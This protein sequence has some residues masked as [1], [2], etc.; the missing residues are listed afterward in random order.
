[1]NKRM[2]FLRDCTGDI[3]G[4]KQGYATHKGAEAATRHPNVKRQLRDTWELYLMFNPDALTVWSIKSEV[5]S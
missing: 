5:V 3:V 4:R 1:M 2:Y